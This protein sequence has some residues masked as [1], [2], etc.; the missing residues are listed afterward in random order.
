M[1]FVLHKDILTNEK[2]DL[3]AFML[4]KC[5]IL[6]SWIFS[7]K[8]NVDPHFTVNWCSYWEDQI[9]FDKPFLWIFFSVQ[10]QVFFKK[11]FC[12]DKTCLSKNYI[13]LHCASLSSEVDPI[14]ILLTGWIQNHNAQ[15]TLADFLMETGPRKHRREHDQIFT[16]IFCLW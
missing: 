2:R 8:S 16:L 10:I 3:F 1:F 15:H 4:F 7:T 5:Y 6:V 9:L 11:F 13:L 12:I 14:T